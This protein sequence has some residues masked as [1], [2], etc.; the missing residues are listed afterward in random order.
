M[1][2]QD[3]K[4]CR[5]PRCRHIHIAIIIIYIATYL[6]VAITINVVSVS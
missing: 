2:E 6:W 1:H 5:T 3:L 4:W